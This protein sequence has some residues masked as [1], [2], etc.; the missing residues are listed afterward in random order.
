MRK[1]M[2]IILCVLLSFAC[3]PL[4]KVAQFDNIE[5]SPTSELDIYTSFES[6]KRQ[7]KEIALITAK[8][9]IVEKSETELIEDLKRRAMEIGADAIVLQAGEIKSS[10]SDSYTFGTYTTHQR[11]ARATAIVYL[12]KGESK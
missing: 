8:D 5:R 12:K 6:I 4:V 2:I 7:Y 1:R 3:T 10:T 9:R 11:I